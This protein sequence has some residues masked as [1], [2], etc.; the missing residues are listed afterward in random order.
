MFHGIREIRVDLKRANVTDDQE[1][2]ILQRLP[3]LLELHVC[4]TKIF[5]PCLI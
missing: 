2:R 5:V 4:F 3:V 1:W